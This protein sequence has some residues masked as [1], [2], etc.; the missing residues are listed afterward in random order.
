M[1][2]AYNF[3]YYLEYYFIKKKK[4]A[5]DFHVCNSMHVICKSILYIHAF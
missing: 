5:T 3:T 1:A 4:T 2:L